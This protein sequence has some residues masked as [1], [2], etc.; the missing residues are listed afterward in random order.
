LPAPDAVRPPDR[1]D[2]ERA[3]KASELPAIARH[4]LLDLLT[5]TDAGTLVLP[6]RWS[7]SLTGLEDDTGWSRRTVTR[8]LD[9]LE[10][11]GWLARLRPTVHDARVKHRRTAYTVMIPDGL[12]TQAAQS[13]VTASPGLGTGP[14]QARVTASPELGTAGPGASASARLIQTVP[15]QPE[16]PDL[17]EVVIRALHRETGVTVDA[18]WAAGTVE[19]ILS[20]P[21]VKNPRAYLIRIITTDPHRWLPTPQPPPYESRKGEELT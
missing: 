17:T 13:R 1:W 18:D 6:Y 19:A 14:A 12:G 20:R 8:Y 2:A 5:Y 11:E 16:N 21:G 10:A 9:L 4:M 7:P 3:V 15:D